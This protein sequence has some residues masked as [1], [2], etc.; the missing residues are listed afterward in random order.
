MMLQ[1]FFDNI[2]FAPFI[3]I[4][5][6]LDINGQRGLVHDSSR[7]PT[8]TP[9]SAPGGSS[10][11]LKAPKIDAYYLITQVW[12]ILFYKPPKSHWYVELT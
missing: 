6:P 12:Q 3:Y 4:E 8:L 2:I 1:Y 11:L 9:H 10:L 5:D 7:A